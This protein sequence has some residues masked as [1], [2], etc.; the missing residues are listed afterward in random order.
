MARKYSCTRLKRPDPNYC[1][2]EQH[3]KWI[4]FGAVPCAFTGGIR[5]FVEQNPDML[6]GLLAQDDHKH[7]RIL[8]LL[9]MFASIICY[10]PPRMLATRLKVLQ[11]PEEWRPQMAS[12]YQTLFTVLCAL[13]I[14]FHLSAGRDTL[15]MRLAAAL[16]PIGGI[17]SVRAAPSDS[18]KHQVLC[19]RRVILAMVITPIHFALGPV[20]ASGKLEG[21]GWPALMVFPMTGAMLHESVAMHLV[22]IFFLN[23]VHFLDPATSNAKRIGVTIATLLSFAVVTIKILVLWRLPCST[24][25]ASSECEDLDTASIS[26]DNGTSENDLPMGHCHRPALSS[27][28]RSGVDYGGISTAGRS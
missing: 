8:G 18:T 15:G 6:D 21:A 12:D 3:W 2:W 23:A 14:S 16:V 24:E 5:F 1:S 20:R 4:V 28:T 19:W 17:L 11:L 27:R 10:W 25:L 7:W 9:M 13:G 22:E 26:K